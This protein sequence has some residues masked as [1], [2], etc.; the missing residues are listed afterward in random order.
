MQ[1]QDYM[2]KLFLFLFLLGWFSTHAE[3]NTL[4]TT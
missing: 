4:I 3:L 2:H 1:N